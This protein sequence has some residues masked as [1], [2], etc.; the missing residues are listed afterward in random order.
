MN[1]TENSFLRF[2]GLSV[3]QCNVNAVRSYL[4]WLPVLRL[5]SPYGRRT[6]CLISIGKISDFIMLDTRNYH[7]SI[8]TLSWDDNYIYYISNHTGRSLIVG[9]LVLS[10]SD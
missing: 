4:E 1:N 10:K 3:Y 7:R 6:A 9:D 2:S 5:P 8:T